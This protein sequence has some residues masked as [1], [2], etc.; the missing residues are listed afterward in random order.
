M[1]STKKTRADYPNLRNDVVA[2]SEAAKAFAS[3]GGKASQAARRRRKNMRELAAMM[4]AQ[5]IPEGEAKQRLKKMYDIPDDD[6]TTQAAVVA[7]QI[8]SAMRG[9]TMAF[10]TL[11]N[12]QQQ[13]ENIIDI[14]D[15]KPYHVD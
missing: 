1:K 7:G 6:I 14:D 12:L 8:Q 9:N 15:G 10:A 11:V 13:E 4:L 3:M 5:Q 2:G